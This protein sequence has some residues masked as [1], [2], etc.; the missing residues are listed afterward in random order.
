MPKDEENRTHEYEA[1]A[2]NNIK[3]YCDVCIKVTQE[4]HNN[5]NNNNK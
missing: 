3:I 5:N 1:G 4:V 2:E